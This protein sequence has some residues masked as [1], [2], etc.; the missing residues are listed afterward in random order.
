MSE[1]LTTRKMLER[2]SRALGKIDRDGM[3]GVMTLSAQEIE[4]MA[5]S[6][7]T[8]GLVPVRPGDVAPTQLIIPP[9]ASDQ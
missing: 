4:A 9:K 6:L 5:V 3:R 2:A 8:L 7:A 1:P